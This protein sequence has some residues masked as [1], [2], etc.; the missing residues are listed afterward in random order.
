[1]YKTGNQEIG[2]VETNNK[3]NSG[4]NS[5]ASILNF[6]FCLLHSEFK[7]SFLTPDFRIYDNFKKYRTTK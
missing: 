3:A 1:M 5:F 4:V 6:N 2:E 7:S